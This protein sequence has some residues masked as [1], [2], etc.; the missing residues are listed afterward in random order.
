MFSFERVV[1]WFSSSRF[2]IFTFKSI[3]RDLAKQFSSLDSE[4]EDRLEEKIVEQ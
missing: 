2:F 4:F 3:D 1:S